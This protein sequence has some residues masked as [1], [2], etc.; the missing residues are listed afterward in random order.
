MTLQDIIEDIHAL[1]E[2]CEVYER[3]Y[4]ILSETFYA[5]FMQGEE[6]PDDHWVHDW[7]DWAGAYQILLR[8]RAQYQQMIKELQDEVPTLAQII[9][10]TLH[11]ES[12]PI[13]A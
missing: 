4:G 8:R 10:R 1:T 6:P 5:S 9:E 7:S 13:I 11:R 2:D 12:V 3:K